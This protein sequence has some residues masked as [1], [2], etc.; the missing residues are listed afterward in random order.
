[1][2]IAAMKLLSWGEQGLIY[3]AYLEF[4]ILNIRKR[5]RPIMPAYKCGK[6][7]NSYQNHESTPAYTSEETFFFSEDRQ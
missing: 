3:T 6:S 2:L 5:G 4:F 7:K 1:M